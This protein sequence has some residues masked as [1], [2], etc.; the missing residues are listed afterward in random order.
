MKLLARIFIFILFVL[1]LPAP[2]IAGLLGPT[3][4]LCF[5]ASVS[6]GCGSDDSP[7]VGDVFSYFYLEDFEDHLLN[8]PGVSAS[9]GG[10]TSVVFGP[11]IHDSVDADDGVI[12]GSGLDGDSYFSSSGS[13]GITFTF[14]ETVLG[15]LPTHVGIV[16]TDGGGTTFFEA[17][18]S[19]GI[20]MGTIGPVS[21]ATSGNS[22]QTDED[23]LFGATNLEGISSIFISNSSG[24]IEVDHLQYGLAAIPVPSAVWLFGSGLI[25]LIGVTRLKHS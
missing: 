17:F 3:S 20:S 13:T 6:A 16:W 19:N 11:S 8:T 14:D 2:T 22:G 12:D 9:P 7:F 15:T 18:D 24:G 1:C 4:Y 5:D 25:G 21:V 10:V 23:S